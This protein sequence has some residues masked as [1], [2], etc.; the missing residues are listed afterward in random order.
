VFYILAATF[1]AANR[2]QRH[3]HRCFLPFIDA[4]VSNDES[5][6]IH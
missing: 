1:K 3:L 2:S 6:R 5:A 4:A